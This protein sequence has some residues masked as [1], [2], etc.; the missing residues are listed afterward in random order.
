MLPV[1]AANLV[2][3]CLFCRGTDATTVILVAFNTA[4]LSSFKASRW[5]AT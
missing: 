1:V 3:T 4:W 2:L 5:A